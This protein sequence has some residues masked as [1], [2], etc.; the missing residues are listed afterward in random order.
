MIKYLQV[1]SELAERLHEKVLD[2]LAVVVRGARREAVPGN[3]AGSADACG[4]DV[5]EKKRGI[6]NLI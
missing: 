6:I 1:P 2:G 5:P 4:D 3:V